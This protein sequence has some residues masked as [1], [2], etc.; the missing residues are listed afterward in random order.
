MQLARALGLHVGVT[1]EEFQR[2]GRREG[3]GHR[4]GASSRGQ[5]GLEPG[6]WAL[7]FPRGRARPGER[8][9]FAHIC[10]RVWGDRTRSPSHT[11]PTSERTL[12]LWVPGM[13]QPGEPHRPGLFLNSSL[14]PVSP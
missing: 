10:F 12:S 11:H 9:A 4:E 2:P 13:L 14:S 8:W 3:A 1:L 5:T 7:P 6:A